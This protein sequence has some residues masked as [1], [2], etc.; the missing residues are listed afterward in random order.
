MWGLRLRSGCGPEQRVL[1]AETPSVGTDQMMGNGPRVLISGASVAG[2]VLAYWLSRF[3][4]Q[5]TVVERTD[6]LR[7]GTG[8]HAVDLFGPALQIIEWM[9]VLPQVK[10]AGTHTEIISFIRDGHRPVDVPAESMSEGVSAHHVEIMRG[11]LAKI[12]YEVGRNDVAYVFSNSIRSLEETEHGVD[13]AFHY[14][15]PQRFDLVIGADGLHSITRRLTFGEEHQFLHFLGGYL[16]V[17]TVPNYL[18]LH[19]QM[20]GYGDVGRTAALYPVRGTR[21]ARVILLWRTPALHDYDFHDAAAQRRL[22]RNVYDDMGWELPRLLTELENADDLYLDSI[23]TIV[24]ETWTRGRVTLVG[25]AGY[26]PGPAVG[27]GTSLA[28]V[29]AYVL[30]SELAASSSDHARGLAAYEQVLR[31]AVHNSQKIGPAV[32]KRLIP[33][34]RTQLLAMAEVIRLLPRLPR[35]VRRRLTSFGGGPAAMLEAVK[36]RDPKAML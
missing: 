7:F 3:G 29:G 16:A 18:D 21:Q 11:E 12:I 24:M 27:G 33:R 32:M 36:L 26:S 25:D 6:A 34:S 10:E 20:L 2:P 23:S 35:P 1:V 19:Q 5:P 15:S 4:F 30:A 28:V 22:I 31:P 17:F 9:G 14:G 13:V 8:G